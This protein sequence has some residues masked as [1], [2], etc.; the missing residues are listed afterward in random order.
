M[1]QEMEAITQ[2]QLVQR[3]DRLESSVALIEDAVLKAQE[4]GSTRH[5][6]MVSH[7]NQLKEDI[8]NNHK[9]LKRLR[10]RGCFS[11]FQRKECV[12]ILILAALA[13][14]MYFLH[15]YTRV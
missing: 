14:W 1:L 6:E 15:N 12:F 13:F 11:C 10:D 5:E 7:L 2:N 4:E 3:L 8:M 9:I